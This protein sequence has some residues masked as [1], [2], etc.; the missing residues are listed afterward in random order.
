MTSV[1]EGGIFPVKCWTI[2]MVPK[3]FYYRLQNNTKKQD[4][5]CHTANSFLT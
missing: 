5:T 3:E 4:K 2:S 1:L